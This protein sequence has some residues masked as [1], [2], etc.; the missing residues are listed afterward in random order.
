MK[1]TFAG[2]IC[3]GAV[4]LDE[5]VEMVNQSRVHVT[6]VPIEESKARWVRALDALGQLR[7]TNPIRTGGLRL[8][9][10]QLHERR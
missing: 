5:P 7:T 2:T 8:T 6:I 9:R 10:D 3:N 1:T 4:H